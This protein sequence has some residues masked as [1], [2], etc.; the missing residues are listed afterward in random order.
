MNKFNPLPDLSTPCQLVFLSN[1]S[2]TEEVAS[3]ANL[4]KIFLAK[5]TARSNNTFL[6]RLPNLLAR[7]TPN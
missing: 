5:G 2:N 6:P 4:G 3:V 1:L 7:N